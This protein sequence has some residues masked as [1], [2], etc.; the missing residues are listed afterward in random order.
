MKLWENLRKRHE[1]PDFDAWGIPD[2]TMRAFDLAMGHSIR[3]LVESLWHE[4][5]FLTS[6]ADDFALYIAS[7]CA[8]LCDM[9]NG[10]FGSPIEGQLAA[11][12]IWMSFSYAGAIQFAEY[13]EFDFQRLKND[14]FDTPICRLAR[15]FD[16]GKYKADL[17]VYAMCGKASCGIVIECDGHDFHEKTKDQAARDKRRDRE[18]L[19]A[20][21]PVMRF[22]GSEIYKSPVQCMEQV[23]AVVEEMVCRVALDGGFLS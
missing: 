1:I 23:H 20:G 2:Q 7:R 10:E 12:L 18:I 16:I 4:S 22:T 14:G 9:H 8:A 13:P 6:N 11:A 5:P 3:D 15:Q 21:F 17:I 19:T